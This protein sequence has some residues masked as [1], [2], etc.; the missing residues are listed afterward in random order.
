MDWDVV[1]V[2]GSSLTVRYYVND[3]GC[4]LDLNRVE[5]NESDS[6][7]TLRVIVGFTGDEGASCP[8]AYSARITI[9]DLALPLSERQLIGCRPRGSF[10]PKGGYNDPQPRTEGAVC[11]ST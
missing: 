5:V 9:V 10:V 7:V 1:A 3:P 6:T 4:S 8:T 11:R 2:N